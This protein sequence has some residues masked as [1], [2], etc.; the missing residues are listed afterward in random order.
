MSKAKLKS[1]CIFLLKDIVFC[2]KLIPRTVYFTFTNF[3]NRDPFRYISKPPSYT[4]AHPSS[5][6]KRCNIFLAS[7]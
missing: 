3:K 5:P 7:S 1:D 2:K 4:A 6:S